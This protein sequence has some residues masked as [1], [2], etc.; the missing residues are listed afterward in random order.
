M[1]I[2]QSKKNNIT[3]KLLQGRELCVSILSNYSPQIY[4]ISIAAL[5]RALSDLQKETGKVQRKFY[6]ID[7]RNKVYASYQ[8]GYLTDRDWKNYNIPYHNKIK[9]KLKYLFRT[10][11]KLYRSKNK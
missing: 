4:Y 8:N 5:T 2:K 1:K 7:F 6:N 9:F 10:I 3:L 11:K